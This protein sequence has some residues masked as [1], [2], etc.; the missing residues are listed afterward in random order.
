MNCWKQRKTC[1]ATSGLDAFREQSIGDYEHVVD[2]ESL[3]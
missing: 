2:H 3:C 1:L